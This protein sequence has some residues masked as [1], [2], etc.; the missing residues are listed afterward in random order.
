MVRSNEEALRRT[1]RRHQL[2][3]MVPLADSTI[4]EMEQRGEFPRRFALTPR[5]VV[6][7]LSEIQ[8]WLAARRSKPIPRAPKP[9][10]KQRRTRPVRETDRAPRSAS[11][12]G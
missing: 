10:L 7:D 1:I 12:E 2:R 4:Y 5:C 9:D 8:A 6:W 3:E 11:K